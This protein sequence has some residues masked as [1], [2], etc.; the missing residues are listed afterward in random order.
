MRNNISHDP[1]GMVS[2]PH[3]SRDIPL[4]LTLLFPRQSLAWVAVRV[5]LILRGSAS[6]TPC[7]SITGAAARILRPFVA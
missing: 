6:V 2:K 7:A 3:E 4:S 5:A 1:T